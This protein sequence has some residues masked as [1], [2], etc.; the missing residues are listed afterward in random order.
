MNNFNEIYEDCGFN[1]PDVLKVAEKIL[2][3]VKPTTISKSSDNEIAI[4]I[5]K[6]KKQS[7]FLIDNLADVQH[8][9]LKSKNADPTYKVHYFSEGIDFDILLKLI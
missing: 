9:Y 5:K 1:N 6:G 4:T 2:S 7:I 3:K 8:I